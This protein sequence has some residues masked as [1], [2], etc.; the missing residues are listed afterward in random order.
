MSTKL[1]KSDMDKFRNRIAIAAQNLQFV[2]TEAKALEEMWFDLSVSTD[3][4]YTVLSS[5]EQTAIVDMITHFQDVSKFYDNA[6]VGTAD[7]SGSIAPFLLRQ[8]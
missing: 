8:T 6:A 3:D 2:R 5:D 1:T 7:R 4:E